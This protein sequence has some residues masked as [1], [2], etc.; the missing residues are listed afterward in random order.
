MKDHKLSEFEIAIPK[1]PIME[2][3][4]TSLVRAY[5]YINVGCPKCPRTLNWVDDKNHLFCANPDCELFELLFERPS[6]ILNRIFDDSGEQ[7]K[8]DD[9]RL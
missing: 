6:V 4:D 1:S 9:N 7:K 3:K 2:L 8:V 5:L